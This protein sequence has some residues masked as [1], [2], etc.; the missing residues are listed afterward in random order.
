ML[1]L[2]KN[3]V[4]VRSRLGLLLDEVWIL[5]DHRVLSIGLVLES[6]LER[7][8]KRIQRGFKGIS[9]RGIVRIER[10]IIL[11]LLILL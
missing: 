7:I 6:L 1:D 3:D 8:A 10:Q 11:T 4:I 5:S 9:L 2:L